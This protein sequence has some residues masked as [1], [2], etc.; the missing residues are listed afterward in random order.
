MPAPA[1]YSSASELQY[2]P[3]D[4]LERARY[5]FGGSIDLDPASDY[6]ANKTVRAKRYYTQADDGLI[7]PWGCFSLWLNPPFT[8]D[9]LYP[10]G[11]PVLSERTGKPIRERVIDRWVA[12]WC[13]ATD[14][15]KLDPNDEHDAPEACTALLLIPARTDT[16]WFRP[17][18]GSHM[19][20][21]EGR[22]HY[23]GSKAGAP[24]P[25]VLVYRGPHIAR[26]YML[27][28]DVGECGTFCKQ[29]PAL[30]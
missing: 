7:R 24:F 21:I 27:F 15:S 26:F 1:L 23:S 30:G 12:R 28:D 11:T 19:C 10:D 29:V 14:L 20:F 16:Q 8:I 9:K 2:T 3:A 25:S 4:I 22:L 5:L 17:L 6:E 18:W 13:A